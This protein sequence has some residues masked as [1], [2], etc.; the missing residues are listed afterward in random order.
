MPEKL[1]LEEILKKNPK[2][3]RKK[4]QEALDLAEKLRRLGLCRRGYR[5]ATPFNRKQVRVPD[6]FDSRTVKLYRP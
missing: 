2:I 3:D 6:E 1:V 4:L 5:L